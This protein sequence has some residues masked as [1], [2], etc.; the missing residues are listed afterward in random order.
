MSDAAMLLESGMLEVAKRIVTAARREELG[1]RSYNVTKE[2]ARR[3]LRAEVARI[4][5]CSEK[6]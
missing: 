4:S 1:C 3:Q 6:K 5:G 2:L